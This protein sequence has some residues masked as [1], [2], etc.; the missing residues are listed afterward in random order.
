MNLHHH[1]N[2]AFFEVTNTVSDGFSVLEILLYFEGIKFNST[3]Y[4]ILLE[5][6]SR[7]SSFLYQKK[8][9]PPL[10]MYNLF[11]YLLPLQAVVQ[12]GLH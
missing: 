7:M 2:A 12:A 11:C 10:T 1:L 8:K 3:E 6:I 9:I 5:F 4:C